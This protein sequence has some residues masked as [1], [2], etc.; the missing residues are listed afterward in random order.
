MEAG[1]GKV[2]KETKNSIITLGG[3]DKW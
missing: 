1:F 3:K 2:K